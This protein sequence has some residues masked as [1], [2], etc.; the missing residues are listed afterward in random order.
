MIAAWWD[1]IMIASWWD[2]IMIA[3]WWDVIMIASWWD[4]VMIASWWDVIMIA[5]WWDVIM[6]A[7]W[8]D[9]NMRKKTWAIM[10]V[11]A[12]SDNAALDAG[13]CMDGRWRKTLFFSRVVNSA[14]SN[15]NHYT[16]ITLHCTTA[17]TRS[18]MN[19]RLQIQLQLYNYTARPQTSCGSSSGFAV[20]S[21]IH[22]NEFVL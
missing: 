2:E 5:S 22:S 4:V 13:T 9:A 10:S 1:V 3:S 16:Y 11:A 14:V 17:T 18:T 19:L 21:I 8:R 15:N 20:P 12:M 7:S 6:I